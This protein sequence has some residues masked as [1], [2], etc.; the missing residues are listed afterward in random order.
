[1]YDNPEELKELFE[2]NGNLFP[3]TT[4]YNLIE[5]KRF[6]DYKYHKTFIDQ[7]ELVYDVTNVTMY[8]SNFMSQNQSTRYISPRVKNKYPAKDLFKERK[9]DILTTVMIS[10][11]KQYTSINRKVPTYA[12][13][14][15]NVGGFYNSL[16]VFS[17]VVSYLFFKPIDELQMLK[18][19]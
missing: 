10:A 8:D 17:L 9:S 18:A 4:T 12:D 3:V 14:I 5:W 2:K 13:A 11:G 16:Y 19:W 7:T 1:M 15:S 6:S